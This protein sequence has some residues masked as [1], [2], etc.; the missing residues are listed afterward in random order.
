[1]H[2]ILVFSD[3]VFLRVCVDWQFTWTLRVKYTNVF[4]FKKGDRDILKTFS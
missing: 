1:M 4:T 2:K 3:V